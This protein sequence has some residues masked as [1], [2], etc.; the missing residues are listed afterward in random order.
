MRFCRA[1]PLGC[2]AGKLQPV[3][4]FEAPVR[5]WHWLHT[6]SFLV[7]A[8]TGYLIAHPL[9]SLVGE[10]SAHFQMGNL[11]LIH[12][13]AAYVF[14]IGFVVRM[15]WVFVGNC[16]ARE[17]FLPTIWRPEWWRWLWWEL[18]YYASFG[19][20]EKLVAIGHNPLAQAAMFLFNTLG[21]IFMIFTGFALYGQ[22]LGDGS[23]ADV[24]FGWVIPLLG[25]S[26]AVRSWHLLVMW[27][28]V[29]F[30]IIH[31]Y[32][33]VRSDVISHESSVSTI[34]GGWRMFHCD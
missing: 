32:M 16:H 9:P 34:I 18:R 11:R 3:Y 15:Y 4:V 6:F 22:G 12:F 30:A 10:A 33:A 25:G 24:A 14:A 20:E 29:V 17:I 13:V 2:E 8:A 19:T 5:I 28:M 23:W 27:L 21:S 31:I 26:A 7:L 1:Q